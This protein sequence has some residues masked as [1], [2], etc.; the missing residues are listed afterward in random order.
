MS[1]RVDALILPD[2]EDIGGAMRAI[3]RNAM[4]TVFVVDT[5]G[6]MCGILTDGDIRRAL[7]KG[8]NLATCV[9]EAMQTDYVFLP[10]TAT[11]EEILKHLSDP[12]KIIPLVDGSGRPVD[13]ACFHKHHRLPVME[14]A[15]D[16]KELDYVMECVMKNWISSQGGFV[17]RF[18]KD[19]ARFL[20][21]EEAVAVSNGTAA[22]HLAL[23]ALG[24]GPGDEVIVPDLTFAASINTILYTGA[25]PVLVDVSPQTWTMDPAAVEAAITPRTKAIMPVHLYG[26]PCPMDEIL[27]LAA[28]AECFVVEDAAESLGS[29][30]KG[31]KTGA[32]GHAGC[33]SFFGNKVITTG[34]GGMVIFNDP[35][36]TKRARILRDHGMSPAKR[37]WHESVGFNYRLTNLQAAV[38][39]AQLERAE[40]LFETRDAI[41]EQYDRYLRELPGIEFSPRSPWGRQVPW[42]YCLLISEDDRTASRDEIMDHLKRHGIESRPLFYPLHQMPPYR[43]FAAPGDA[44]PATENLSRRGISL[45]SGYGLTSTEIR[46]ICA[47]LKQGLPTMASAA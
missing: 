1:T 23:T 38:G 39:V 19:F 24:L 20:G 36:L 10:S 34:E 41:V 21:V 31:V 29:E 16:G 26:H 12:I 5:E 45:P 30:Y 6:R 13:Y 14:P 35:E 18:E 43:Q 22:L 15:L 7:L 47:V 3:D 27:A 46:Y 28:R 33:F 17:T 40:K 44:Y 42:L 8:C 25:T 37:Y 11:P 32:L 2:R 4:G 9:Q